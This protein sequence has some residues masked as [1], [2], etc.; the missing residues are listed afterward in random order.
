MD[1]LRDRFASL[2]RVPVPDVWS[3]VER[4]LDGSRATPAIRVVGAGAVPR[5]VSDV[6]SR[7]WI[8]PSRQRPVWTLITVALI[9]AALVVGALGVGSG[10]LR[11]RAQFPPSPDASLIARPTSP[12][13]SPAT[14]TDPTSPR[15][16]TPPPNPGSR[17]WSTTGKMA[18]FRDF[19][20]QAA[21]MSDG[22]VLVVGG[23]AEGEPTDPAMRSADLFDP[24]T[25][26]WT[27]TETTQSPH[28]GGH[29]VTGLQDGTV[30][31][32]GGYPLAPA[33]SNPGQTTAAELFDPATG[34]WN[35]TGSMTVARTRHL[36]T[37]LLDGSVL[38]V[39]GY[40]TP[41]RGFG[42]VATRTA[43]IFDPRS[44]TWARTASL[45]MIRVARSASLLPDGRVLVLG[46]GGTRDAPFGALEVYDPA[47]R[48]WTGGR[49]SGDLG[50]D[51]VLPPMVPLSDGRLL[52]L[53]GTVFQPD[54]VP[55]SAAV[56]NPASATWTATTP[57]LRRMSRTATLLADG[58][59]LVSDVG[60][61]EIYDPAT[62]KWTNA[63]LPTVPD[64]R[65]TGYRVS[66]G[67]TG[68]RVD[69]DW[70][71]VDTA[72]L[73]RDGRVLLTIANRAL[74]YDPTGQR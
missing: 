63:G 41:A 13:A 42:Q 51:G 45:T 73:L 8:T 4:R 6:P 36:A 1:D 54:S 55:V 49:T 69:P 33:N 67:T 43:E 17:S 37:L 21:L 12:P 7:R 57:P 25:G 29:T 34:H 71:E 72:T 27:A 31:V 15:P 52:G 60:A 28:W 74:V 68:R 35:K 11:L 3:D 23:H 53:C 59:V 66:G 70:Y 10:L 38:A 5:S 47:R 9:A 20:M 26:Q 50:C 65:L 61:G 32:A 56:F 46:D 16:S 58:R 40:Q 24:A 18:H 44:G 2:D 64:A 39:G 30:L 19:A 48:T 62:A 14:T 22:R